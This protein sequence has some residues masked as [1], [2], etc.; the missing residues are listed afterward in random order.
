MLMYSVRWFEWCF[1]FPN[2]E[3]KFI[4]MMNRLKLSINPNFVNPESRLAIWSFRFAWGHC[5][6]GHAPVST[7]H[8]L[9]WNAAFHLRGRLITSLP[10]QIFIS[11]KSFSYFNFYFTWHVD[12]RKFISS[13]ILIQIW[14]DLLW[15]AP[16]D[17]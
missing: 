9:K 4:T 12:F 8:A 13:S 17:L 6:I 1:H 11:F 3:Q 14:W 5:F 7:R 10:L 15:N 16:L 2:L